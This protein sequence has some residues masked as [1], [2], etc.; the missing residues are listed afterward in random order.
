[1]NF[2]K[3]GG[4]LMNLLIIIALTVLGWVATG[5]VGVMAISTVNDHEIEFNSPILMFS[6][7]AIGVIVFTIA[8]VRG[9]IFTVII[10]NRSRKLLAAMSDIAQGDGDLTKRLDVPSTGCYKKTKCG[11]KE[12][13]AYENQNVVVGAED[14]LPPVVTELFQNYPN[15]FNPRTTISFNLTAKDAKNAKLEIYNIK[16]QRIK[17]LP[18]S[19][20]KLRTTERFEIIWDGTDYNNQPVTSGI[21]FYKLKTGEEVQTRK[22]LLLK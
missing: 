3:S 2:F 4:I 17:N 16:G 7:G 6:L 12:C 18:L 11:K 9:V 22:M 13:G 14:E 20:D 19:F 5:A 21:Y 1:M 10:S 15:P 8:I